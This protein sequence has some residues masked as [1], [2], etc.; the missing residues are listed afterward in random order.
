MNDRLRKALKEWKESLASVSNQNQRRVYNRVVA[1]LRGGATV[2]TAVGSQ[3]ELEDILLHRNGVLMVYENWCPPSQRLKKTLERSSLPFPLYFLDLAS[4]DCD[5]S[6]AKS[7][8]V[9]DM[10]KAVTHYPTVFF[11]QGKYL[12]KWDGTGTV[13]DKAMEF[14]D[15][16]RTKEVD[17]PTNENDTLATGW[18][19]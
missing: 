13:Q 16:H 7:R 17:Y 3:E 14:F 12:Q 2:G 6:S 11:V 19:R 15:E 4:A 10:G 18:T 9:G 1:E 5:L 8:F